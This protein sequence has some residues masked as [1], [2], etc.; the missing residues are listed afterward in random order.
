MAPL[1]YPGQNVVRKKLKYFDTNE[2]LVDLASLQPTVCMRIPGSG[3][4]R[5][6]SG[7]TQ[8]FPER[9]ECGIVIVLEDKQR[10]LALGHIAQTHLSSPGHARIMLGQFVK[11]KDT[12]CKL[13]GNVRD[14]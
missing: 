7:A 1:L 11:G 9:T 14:E 10:Q 3:H 5:A 13:G 4:S 2:E 6:Q 8:I 12:E